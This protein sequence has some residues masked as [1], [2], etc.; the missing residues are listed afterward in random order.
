M[1]HSEHW[2]IIFVNKHND[3]RARFLV[4]CV[5][6]FCQSV[7]GIYLRL[8]D[9][10]FLLFCLQN[11]GEISLQLLLVHVFAAAEVEVEHRMFCPLFFH[12]LDGKPSEQVFLAFK[13]A[14]EGG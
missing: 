9:P 2:R 10:P 12:L 7:V 4:G 6:K 14:L 13:I 3:L 5:Y 8:G 1:S 11:E